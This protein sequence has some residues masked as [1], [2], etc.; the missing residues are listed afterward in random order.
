ML[1][2]HALPADAELHHARARPR[3]DGRAYRAVRRTRARPRARGEG[4]RGHPRGARARRADA[5]RSERELRRR[6]AERR[7]AGRR[8][9]SGA[10]SRSWRARWAASR[11]ST[12]TAPPPRRSRAR[13]STPS[14]TSTAQHNANAHRGSTSSARR[15]PRRTRGRGRRSPAFL[16]SGRTPRDSCSPAARP[17]RS[18]SWR[19]GGRRQL[20]R[21]GDEILS[22]R[23]STTRTSCRGSSPRTRPAATLRYIPLTDDGTLDL[24]DARRAA[25]R[26]ARSA[27]GDRACRTRSARSHP[28]AQLADAAHAARRGGASSTAPRRAPHLPIDVDALDADFLAFSG[29]KMLGPDGE[30]AG[31]SR[32]G[33]RLDAMDPMFGGGDMIR[34]V[35]HDH[36]TWNECRSGSRPARCRSR[37]RSGSPPRCDYLEAPRH[38]RG[39][40]ARGGDHARTR[41]TG[42]SRPG[43]RSSVPKEL[44]S[45]AAP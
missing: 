14:P 26:R 24:S 20:L 7:S 4:L 44:D 27:R 15:P 21:E 12:S 8:E 28:S 22:P 36:S 30:R 41:S 40:C 19:T 32:R 33:E 37:S 17:S 5:E 25:H 38:G 9:R 1:T 3:D 10:T 31:C 16:G 11:S 29:H 13:S 2:H 35:F 34:E 18:T 43:P 6:R 39:A 45:A 42:C 23:W